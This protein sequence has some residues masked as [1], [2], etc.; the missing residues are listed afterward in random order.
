MQKHVF[1][2][3][4]LAE[5][6]SERGSNIELQYRDFLSQTGEEGGRK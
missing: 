3:M 1:L 5:K 4:L 6:V 2:L